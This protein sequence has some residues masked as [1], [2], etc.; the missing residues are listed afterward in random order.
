MLV[1]VVQSLVRAFDENLAP[2][3]QTG[4]G[5][6]GQSAED[7]FL[8]KRGLHPSYRQHVKCQ[9]RR[10]KHRTIQRRMIF[11]FPYFNSVRSSLFEVS[12]LSP[13]PPLAR[14]HDPEPEQTIRERMHQDARSQ[15]TGAVSDEIEKRTCPQRRRPIRS[16]MT[17]GESQHHDRE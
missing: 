8:E 9:F 2:L 4:G 15:A 17:E 16:G 10:R 6:P 1:T 13:E 5:E 14:V 11:K 3:N 7:D 12:H